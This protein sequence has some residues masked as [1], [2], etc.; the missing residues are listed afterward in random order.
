MSTCT[1]QIFRGR[2]TDIQHDDC[3]KDL[4]EWVESL[5]LTV[6]EFAKAPSNPH[7]ESS[8]TIGSHRHQ[9]DN[10]PRESIQEFFQCLL[11]ERGAN[12]IPPGPRQ[13]DLSRK[14]KLEVADF[15][16]HGDARALLDWLTSIE[17]YFTWYH[18]EDPQQVTFVKMTL[19]GPA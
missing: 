10:I 18:I 8:S 6:D 7:G 16:G 1:G 9:L 4:Y 11:E 5:Q 14:I 19:K 13:D 15:S 2:L 12:N 3:I 17:D